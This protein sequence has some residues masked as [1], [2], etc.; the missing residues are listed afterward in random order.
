MVYQIAICLCLIAVLYSMVGHGGA[1]GYIAVF[2]IFAYPIAIIRQDALILN[3]L[4]SGIAFFQFHKAGF[5]QFKKFLPFVLGSVPLALLGG[6]IQLSAEWFK[7]AL[8]ILLLVPALWFWIQKS[9]N[10]VQT[11]KM[12]WILAVLIGATLGFIS[13]LTGIGGGVF[14][15]PILILGKW[16]GQK[17][18][19][20]LSAPFIFINS[21]AGLVGSL[22]HQPQ[23]DN[24]I[25][26]F[27][28]VCVLGGIVGSIIGAWKFKPQMLKKMLGIVLLIASIKLLLG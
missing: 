9:D 28:M 4:V 5:F 1:S 24:S 14:L 25:A 26:L 19:A 12:P 6:S 15:S 3:I 13:G 8:G 11:K 17:Q 23:L 27:A 21:I 20:A 22:E 7:I 2:S 10:V 18:T 16:E